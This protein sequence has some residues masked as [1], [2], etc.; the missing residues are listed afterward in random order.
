MHQLNINSIIESSGEFFFELPPQAPTLIVGIC[1]AAL[2]VVG[3]LIIAFLVGFLT[4]GVSKS[5]PIIISIYGYLLAGSSIYNFSK[6]FRIIK[7]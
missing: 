6:Q 1:T 5:G 4:L 2:Y 3:G 7:R